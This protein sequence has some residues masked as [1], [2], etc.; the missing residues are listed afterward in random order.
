M[1]LIFKVENLADPYSNCRPSTDSLKY[2]ES[3]TVSACLQECKEAYIV[4]NCSCRDFRFPGYIFIMIFVCFVVVCLSVC[5][6]VCLSVCLPV[7]LSVCRSV[8]LFASLLFEKSV[9]VT[10]CVTSKT[11]LNTR[12]TCLRQN[13]SLFDRYKMC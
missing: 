4:K 13:T 1:L 6:S 10:R 2:S 5:V 9:E 8:C 11:T 3:Y 7:V 12:Y